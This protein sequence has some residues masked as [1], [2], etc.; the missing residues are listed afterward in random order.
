M[1]VLLEAVCE[2]SFCRF[3]GSFEPIFDS[4][5]GGYINFR[6]LPPDFESKIGQNNPENRRS[7][8]SQA[9]S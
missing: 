3:S 8:N 9:A 5:S 6:I 4:K 2:L 7:L 1:H